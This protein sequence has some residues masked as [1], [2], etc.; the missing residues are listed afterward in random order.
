[1]KIVGRLWLRRFW[2]AAAP[3]LSA[4]IVLVFGFIG[5]AG[6]RREGSATRLVDH[7]HSVIEENRQVLARL[8]DAETGERGFIIS[9]DPAYLDPYRGAAADV[10]ARLRVLRQLT[11]DNPAQQARLDTLEAL[12]RRRLAVLETRVATRQRAGFD[13][14]RADFVA[15]GGGKPV[16]DSARHVVAAIEA[17]EQ[18]LLAARSAS[19]RA[20]ER[21]VLW[22]VG[23]GALAAALI[24]LGISLTLSRAAT[25]EAR[26]ATA[27]RLQTDELEGANRQLQEQA[28]E[29]ENLNEELQSTNDQLEERTAEA[30]EA[31]RIKAAFLANMSHDLRTPLNAIMGYVD[32]LDAGVRG[33]VSAEQLSDLQRIKRSGSHLLA[34]ITEVLDFAK[35]EA[36][37]VQLR[38]EDVSVEYV[39]AELEPLV[40]P[41]VKAKGLEFRTECDPNLM[42]RADREKLDQILVNLVGNATKFTDGQGRIDVV[43]RAESNWARLE[44]RDTGEGIPVDQLNAVFAPFVQ[45][46][47]R[48]RPREPKGIGLGLSIS[49]ELAR[50]MAGDLTVTSVLGEGSTF[51]LRLPRVSAAERQS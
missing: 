30:E 1:M 2:W 3:F 39:L 51:T 40:D 6:A 26:L 24:A 17:D 22:I 47:R 44:V 11:S 7:S 9:G 8:V 37:H 29:M 12:V 41:Q 25:T 46:E 45:V 15:K 20:Y 18:R 4:V 34:L 36:G 32:L 28:A 13:S 19:Q 33:P 50:A 43:C 16:M 48:G 10:T 38:I 31:N 27:L 23:A 49:R 5:F 21:A 14:I 35:I 42:V